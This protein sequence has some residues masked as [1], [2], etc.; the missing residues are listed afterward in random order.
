M[1]RV[2]VRSG[3]RQRVRLKGGES[4]QVEGEELIIDL[5]KEFK[6]IDKLY[7]YYMTTY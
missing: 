5:I 7:I 4:W 3:I 1:K 6:T 2:N